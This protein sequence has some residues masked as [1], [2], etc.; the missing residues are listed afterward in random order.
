MKENEYYRL[1]YTLTLNVA[2]TLLRLNPGLTICYVSGTGT[3][4]TEKGGSMW[5]RVKGKTENALLA[6]PFK[7][8]YMFRPGY[9]HPTKGLKNTKGYY[10]ALAWLYPV[11]RT[12]FPKYVCTLQDMGQAMIHAVLSGYAKPVLEVTDIIQLAKS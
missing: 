1:T 6:L 7:R 8:A 9:I 10:T 12:L 5:A 11:W 2:Q 4:S 3:D